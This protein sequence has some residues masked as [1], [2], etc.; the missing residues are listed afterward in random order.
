[1]GNESHYKY[2]TAMRSTYANNGNVYVCK[3]GFILTYGP[4]V[5]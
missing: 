3:K 2:D 5:Y 4:Y 1:M